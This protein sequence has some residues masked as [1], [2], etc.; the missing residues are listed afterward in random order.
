[1]P[2]FIGLFRTISCFYNHVFTFSVAVCGGA[3]YVFVFLNIQL[4]FTSRNRQRWTALQ[5]DAMSIRF[6]CFVD[7]Q[8]RCLF[9]LGTLIG[10]GVTFV[11]KYYWLLNGTL[12]I[13][14]F[15][16]WWFLY[17]TVG[18]DYGL[19]PRWWGEAAG[20]VIF[21]W[22]AGVE[23]LALVI[24]YTLHLCGYFC[25][26]AEST[27]VDLAE[28][29][30]ELIV[31]SVSCFALI[32]F[33]S[34]RPTAPLILIINLISLHRWIGHRVIII[35]W[36]FTSWIFINW[37]LCIFHDAYMSIF[38]HFF[39]FALKSIIEFVCVWGFAGTRYVALGIIVC[40]RR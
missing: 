32:L 24:W 37:I 16:M 22:A 4:R 20:D 5:T 35:L 19:G 38:R 25:S 1:M 8:W 17:W 26:L 11:L 40:S 2:G 27:L 39:L 29:D 9:S 13:I 15:C 28:F 18:S 7:L 3:E 34:F 33:H 30:V 6:W 31:V 21:L 12:R 14:I 10:L 36:K 23:D